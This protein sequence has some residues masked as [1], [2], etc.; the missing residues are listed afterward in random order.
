MKKFVVY[1]C[2]EEEY[3]KSHFFSLEI[4]FKKPQNSSMPIF[5]K[6]F[7]TNL[8]QIRGGMK[9][10]IQ[11]LHSLV[12]KISRKNR[13]INPDQMGFT[14]LELIS[15]NTRKNILIFSMKSFAKNFN[16]I[17]RK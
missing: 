16:T 7:Q 1:F 2:F 13:R 14:S 4:K 11:Y 6:K 15:S 5:G 10:T 12:E 9:P 3:E 8:S 17:L